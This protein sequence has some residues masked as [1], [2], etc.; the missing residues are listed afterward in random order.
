MANQI[1][2][3]EMYCSTWF[4]DVSNEVTIHNSGQPTCFI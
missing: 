1:N 4:G 3:G 2:W